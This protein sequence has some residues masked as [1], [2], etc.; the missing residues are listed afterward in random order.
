M[1]YTGMGYRRGNEAGGWGRSYPREYPKKIK[2][3]Y[4][5]LGMYNLD[6]KNLVGALVSD[7][8]KRGITDPTEIVK[9]IAGAYTRDG[10]EI[11]KHGESITTS[12]SDDSSTS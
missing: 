7:A 11:I 3:F 10:K 2:V 12:R 5:G 6:N 8:I 4:R 1:P 9:H